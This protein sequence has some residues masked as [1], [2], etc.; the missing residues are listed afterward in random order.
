MSFFN[1]P[2]LIALLVKLIISTSDNISKDTF[3]VVIDSFKSTYFIYIC[4]IK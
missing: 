4:T 3:Y 2:Y 1:T